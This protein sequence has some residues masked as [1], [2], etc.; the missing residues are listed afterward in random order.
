MTDYDR[1]LTIDIVNGGKIIGI[2]I[3]TGIYRF[4]AGAH[5]YWAPAALQLA[6]AKAKFCSG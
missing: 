3:A 4:S 6:I 1:V 2:G 5:A